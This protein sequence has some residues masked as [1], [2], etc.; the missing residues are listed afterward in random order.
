MGV[1]GREVDR[2]VGRTSMGRLQQMC[3]VGASAGSPSRSPSML[4]M[5]GVPLLTLERDPRPNDASA[6]SIACIVTG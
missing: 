2:E 4:A 6:G 3:K 1:N 5:N